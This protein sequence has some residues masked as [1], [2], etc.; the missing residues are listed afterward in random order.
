MDFGMFLSMISHGTQT[1]TLVEQPH[2]EQP[3][4]CA[5]RLVLLDPMIFLMALTSWAML[6]PVQPSGRSLNGHFAP[7]G[8]P[9]QQTSARRSA[10][11]CVTSGIPLISHDPSVRVPDTIITSVRLTPASVVRFSPRPVQ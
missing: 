2:T 9:V 7:R 8:P 5:S 3:S 10:N 11:S 6:Q 1:F 4:S